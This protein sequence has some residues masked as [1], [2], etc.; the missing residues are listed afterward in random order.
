MSALILLVG[1]NRQVQMCGES[2]AETAVLVVG[3]LMKSGYRVLVKSLLATP[4]PPANMVVLGVTTEQADALVDCF[5]GVKGHPPV[6]QDL[7]LDEATAL[8]VPS[9]LRA[10]E[11]QSRG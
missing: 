3:R 7:L 2:D 5:R 1:R 11:P 4:R 8:G 9:A 10:L 6:V